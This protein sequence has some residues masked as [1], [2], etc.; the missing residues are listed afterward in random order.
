MQLTPGIENSMK[1]LFVSL[2][3]VVILAATSAP[4]HA[5]PYSDDMVKCFVKS[6]TDVDKT[7]LVKWIFSM[8]ALH[9]AVASIASVSDEQRADMNRE[10][11]RLVERLLTDAC[12]AESKAAFKFEG[13]TALVS[14]MQSLAQVASAGLFSDPAVAAGTAGFAAALD[15]AKIQKFLG[16]N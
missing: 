15:N 5:G 4:A 3:T 9:P 16:S 10:T 11:A 13:P 7:K 6:T 1:S 8:A 14:A 2:S 12:G